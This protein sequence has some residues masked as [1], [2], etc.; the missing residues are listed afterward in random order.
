VGE[1]ED[2]FI[3]VCEGAWGGLEEERRRSEKSESERGE[4]SNG[5]KA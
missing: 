4:G 1:G 2:A 5:S 3:E